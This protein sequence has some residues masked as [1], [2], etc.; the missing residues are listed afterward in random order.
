MIKKEYIEA[1][2]LLGAVALAIYL[3]KTDKILSTA[4]VKK[5]VGTGANGGFE[6]WTDDDMVYDDHLYKNANGGLK[7]LNLK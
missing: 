6:N 7:G 5:P 4:Q 1:A 2:I 3:T